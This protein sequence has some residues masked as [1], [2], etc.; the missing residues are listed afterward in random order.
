MAKDSGVI[1]SPAVSDRPL[2]TSIAMTMLLVSLGMLFG[3]L[4]LGLAVYRSSAVSWP[5]MGLP[6]VTLFVP[7]IGAL[8]IILSSGTYHLMSKSLGAG[9]WWWGWTAFLGI[10]FLANQMY[11]WRWMSDHGLYTTSGIFASLIYA[12]TWIH[13]AH[14]IVALAALIYVYPAL[15]K[16]K[17][18]RIRV[19]SVG[20]FWHFLTIVWLLIYFSLFVF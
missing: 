9:R 11:L 4:F 6:R 12:F 18:N 13:A 5:P 15:D 3:C 20:K 8:I 14:I 16:K 17:L 19:I 1:L 7:T 10:G 2:A